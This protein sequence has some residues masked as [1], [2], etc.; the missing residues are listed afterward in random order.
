[1][2][3]KSE[4]FYDAVYSW[5]DYA[6]EAADL[7]AI[8]S[9]RK[10]PA[11]G[12]LLDVACGTGGHVPHLSDAFA[13]EGIDLDPAMIEIARTRHPGIP[14]HVADMADFNLGRQ[15]DVVISLFSSIGYAATVER[16]G[17]AI[18]CMARHVRPGGLLVVEPF[19][20]PEAWRYDLKLPGMNVVDRP[21]LKL[22]RMARWE[23]KGNQVTAEFHYLVG[24][25]DGT[26]EHFVE[27]H[28][29][30]LFTV[31]EMHAAF[32]AAGLAAEHDA[33]GLMGRGLYVATQPL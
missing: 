8:I 27:P 12:A 7:K 15:F 18:A 11:G 28:V 4:R 25:D 16:L 23:P 13:V 19:F 2:F 6:R 29:M 10:G 3:S 26:I 31:G 5:K 24:N 21:D 32:T 30:G 20:T 14:F 33:K 17:K 22:V 1:M 9:A